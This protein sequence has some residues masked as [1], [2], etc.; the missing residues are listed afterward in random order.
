MLSYSTHVIPHTQLCGWG[1]PQVP[2]AMQNPY[3]PQEKTVSSLN[4]H[5]R[6][7]SALHR[8][9]FMST[10]QFIDFNFFFPVNC[11]LLCAA[12]LH[13]LNSVLTLSAGD[14]SRRTGLSQSDVQSLLE[15][16]SKA[17]FP[18]YATKLTA[19]ELY[20]TSDCSGS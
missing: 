13:K 3:L 12:G 10:E 5:P 7:L 14:L 19:L 16:S 15:A 17:V 1:D 6:I 2:A 8:G 20:K 11:L 18:R 4:L 9:K